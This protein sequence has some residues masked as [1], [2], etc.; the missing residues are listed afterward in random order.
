MPLDETINVNYEL[1]KDIDK[2]KVEQA[3]D[4]FFFVYQLVVLGQK[5]IDVSAEHYQTHLLL[6]I[7]PQSGSEI[8]AVLL[9]EDFA[10]D[11][12]IFYTGTVG[13]K[14]NFSSEIYM[15]LVEVRAR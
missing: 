13:R 6:K 10:R 4:D 8:G 3:L 12:E 9:R 2:E 14:V 7:S 1:S 5:G 11:P 15:Y